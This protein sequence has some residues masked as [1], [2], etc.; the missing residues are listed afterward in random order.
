MRMRVAN[1]FGAAG[2]VALVVSAAMLSVVRVHGQS[3][4]HVTY[5]GGTVLKGNGLHGEV[6]VSDA[7]KL[8]FQGSQRLAIAY[9]HIMSYESTNHR[10]VHVGLLTEGVWRLLAP[11]PMA[12]QLSLSFHDEAGAAQVVVLEMSPGD[13]ALLV[14]VL[15]TRVPRETSRPA[16]SLLPRAKVGWKE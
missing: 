10:T 4:Q 12:K 6:S 7:D 15:K 11:Y 1:S 5:L 16:V 3:L 9:D 14:E 13:E 8:V 2:R